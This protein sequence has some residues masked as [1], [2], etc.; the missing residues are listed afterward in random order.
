MRRGQDRGGIVLIG[1][2]TTGSQNALAIEVRDS[3]AACRACQFAVFADKLPSMEEE[4]DCKMP[5]NSR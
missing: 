1:W 3:L 2:T 5:F 4:I